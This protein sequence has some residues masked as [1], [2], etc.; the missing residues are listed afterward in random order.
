MNILH[1]IPSLYKHHGGPPRATVELLGAL[2]SRGIQ[3]TLL[4]TCGKAES[5]E[6]KS[7]PFQV[8]QFQGSYGE[9]WGI[10][11]GLAKW[12]SQNIQSFDLVHIHSFFSYTSLVAAQ[13]AHKHK[14]L[15]IIR[16]AGVLDGFCFKQ[17]PIRKQLYFHLFGKS[18][19]ERAEAVQCTSV[20]E[21]K[22]IG[23]LN[24]RA[25]CKVIPLATNIQ[26]LDLDKKTSKN[27]VLYLSRL[28]PDKGLD[29]LL[30]AF[31]FLFA[32]QSDI[33]LKLAGSGEKGF[34]KTL[35]EEVTRL[36]ISKRVEFLGF[37]EGGAKRQAF[38]DAS[39]FVLP[40]R[41]E[42]FG[43]SVVEAMACGLP[44]I[45]SNQV[46]VSDVIAR[47]RCGLVLDLEAA[48]FSEAIGKLFSNPNE[49]ETMG[50]RGEAV[51]NRLFRWP[52]VSE[53][54]HKLY[55]DILNQSKTKVR[56]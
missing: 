36:G 49:A 7:L 38:S 5:I 45:V 48:Q 6:T 34:T 47:E 22:E 24:V 31:A 12:L 30:R 13:M 9:R 2:Q 27:T 54:L 37:V 21:E 15:F 26:K 14:R 20:F 42:N 17:K 25:K 32:K 56:S 16:P 23:R 39:V 33:K 50:K 52:Q 18:I 28:H 4:T 1:V 43:I 41:H 19:L 29:I 10:A 35:R 51:V 44:V 40:S 46:G 3:V 55:K 11:K 8:V 53:T